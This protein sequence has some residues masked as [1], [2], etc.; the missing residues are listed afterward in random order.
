MLNASNKQKKNLP[1]AGKPCTAPT[2][3]E[4]AEDEEHRTVPTKSCHKTEHKN[5]PIPYSPTAWVL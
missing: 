5:E 3:K 1:Q 4:G 2:L